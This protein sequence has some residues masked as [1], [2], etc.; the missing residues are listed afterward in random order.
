M[1]RFL[2][3]HGDWL[4]LPVNEW[5]SAVYEIETPLGINSGYEL[6]GQGVFGPDEVIWVNTNDYFS[7]IQSGA[8][9]LP[10]GNTLI[11]VATEARIL[12]VNSNG[13]IIWEYQ[14][15][16]G[17]MI[18]RAQKYGLD[19]LFPSFILGDVNFDQIINI[20]DV[21][22]INDMLSGFG[23]NLAPTADV[24]SDGTIDISDIDIL[25]QYIMNI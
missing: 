23:Y 8:F 10:N 12:E 22:I 24:N 14:L 16:D 20:Q 3:I 15:N 21:L 2:I 7:F 17:Q 19:Y 5:E 13:Q 1:D 11:T 9:R 18:A 25:I 6:N 4:S